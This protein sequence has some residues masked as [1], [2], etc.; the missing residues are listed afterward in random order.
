MIV[1]PN[2]PFPWTMRKLLMVTFPN[3]PFPRTIKN[4]ANGYLSIRSLSK[5]HKKVA[6]GYLSKWFLSKDLKFLMVTFPNDPFP[7]T[8]RK[9]KSCAR[10]MSL[11]FML[12]GTRGSWSIQKKCQSYHIK[13]VFCGFVRNINEVFGRK[14]YRDV[15]PAPTLMFNMVR[16]S[17]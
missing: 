17:K 7:R 4:V 11:P 10:I 2:D 3:D 12:W 9:L 13:E 16:F 1:F 15:A 8:I 6:N 14:H 5:D